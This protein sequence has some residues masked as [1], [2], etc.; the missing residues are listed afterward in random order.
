MAQTQVV[1]E[2]DKGEIVIELF[3]A[4]APKSVANFLKYVEAGFYDETIFHRIIAGFVVQGGGYKA[5]GRERRKDINSLDYTPVE[6]EAE[7]GLKNLRGSLSMARTSDPH[8]ATSQFFINLND[9]AFLDH[10]GQDGWG[11]AVFGKV[12]SGMDAVDAMAKVPTAAGD[13]PVEDIAVI[14][15]Y[16]KQ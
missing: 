16:V 1:M 5:D 3:D 8:S 6:N 4:Q 9:N 7:N 15:A 12:T 14:K 13:K 10:P 2:T 11:Y